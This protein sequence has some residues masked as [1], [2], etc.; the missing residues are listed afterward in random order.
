MWQLDEKDKKQQVS[1]TLSTRTPGYLLPC[2]YPFCDGGPQPCP[3]VKMTSDADGM[4][5]NCAGAPSHS[6]TLTLNPCHTPGLSPAQMMKMQNEIG[7]PLPCPHLEMRPESSFWS[8]Y[9]AYS[10]VETETCSVDPDADLGGRLCCAP[11]V[12]HKSN[13]EGRKHGASQVSHMPAGEASAS[14][15]AL[16]CLGVFLG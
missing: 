11:T 3:L 2:L 5:L 12:S 4:R 7:R 13:L 9:A 8:L 1:S 16:R 6:S 14:A 10:R 15:W